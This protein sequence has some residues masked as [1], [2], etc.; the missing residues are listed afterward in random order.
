MNRKNLNK[1]RRELAQLRRSPQKAATRESLAGRLGR[2]LVKRGKEPMWE[3]TEF[4]ELF[5]LSIPRHGG[6]DLSQG[7]QKSIL[8]QLEDDVLAWEERLGDDEDD[9]EAE[10]EGRNGEDTGMG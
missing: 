8:D 6:R 4:G 2:K 7:V 10:N 5:V 1:V 3:N 9:K